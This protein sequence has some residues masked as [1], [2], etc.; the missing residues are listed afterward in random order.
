MVNS[1]IAKAQLPE[2]S[3]NFSQNILSKKNKNEFDGGK[4]SSEELVQKMTKYDFSSIWLEKDNDVLGFIGDDYQR[5][6]IRLI[7]VIKC[8]DDF[9]KYYVYGKSMVKNNIC[10][11]IGEIKLLHI[12]QIIFDDDVKQILFEEHQDESEKSNRYLAPEYVLLAQYSFFE[13]QKEKSTGKFNGILK[14]N[15]YIHNDNVY[16]NDFRIE[17]SDKF[18]NNQYVGVWTSYATGKSK[19]CNWGD[20]RIPF[21]GNL[22]IGIGEFSPN[23]TYYQKGWDSY[24]NQKPNKGWWK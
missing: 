23:P 4:L 14:T 10:I 13:D 15:F 5:L 9:T 19:I 17:M 21:S 1:A 20:F 8:S 6:N 2:N 18:N 24:S 3:V 22:D 12:K 7:S 11:F 16:Y